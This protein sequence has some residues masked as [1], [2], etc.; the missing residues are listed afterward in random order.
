MT[1]GSLHL[2]RSLHPQLIWESGGGGGEV[3]LS[4]KY[5]IYKFSFRCESMIYLVTDLAITGDEL[6]PPP[7]GG[8]C[9][10][11]LF[12]VLFG[13]LTSLSFVKRTNNMS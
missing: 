10:H 7:L 13:R 1:G 11:L 3:W 5:G 2:E 9:I 6:C 4:G 12:V 8:F